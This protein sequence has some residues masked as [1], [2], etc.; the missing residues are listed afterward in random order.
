MLIVALYMND[1]PVPSAQV[2]HPMPNGRFSWDG[3]L[4]T[5]PSLIT[6]CIHNPTPCCFIWASLTTSSKEYPRQ[7]LQVSEV[8]SLS[9]HLSRHLVP[10]LLSLGNEVVGSG[11]FPKALLTSGTWAKRSRLLPEPFPK[12][13]KSLRKPCWCLRT[14]LS[15]VIFTMISAFISRQTSACPLLA[16]NTKLKSLDEE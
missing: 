2:I 16:Y 1:L 3:N 7:F 5:V 11:D 15:N 8:S 6:Q 9:L 12:G 4:I 14:T 10:S 13:L